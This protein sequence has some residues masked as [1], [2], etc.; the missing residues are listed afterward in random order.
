[1][2]H[3]IIG[4][5]WERNWEKL[6]VLFSYPAEIRRAIYTTNAIE[7]LNHSLRRVLKN[8]KAF[9]SED[10]LMKVLYLSIERAGKKWTMPIQNWGP[11]LAHF[12]IQFGER[13]PD[14]NR[15]DI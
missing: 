11:A 10:A 13:V 6:S 3:P 15:I 14:V 1:M 4:E 7:S 8:K 5:Q 12:S 9:P 2:G